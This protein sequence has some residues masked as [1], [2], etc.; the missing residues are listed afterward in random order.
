M[1]AAE[2]KKVNLLELSYILSIINNREKKSYYISIYW[3]NELEDAIRSRS[4]LAVWRT[5]NKISYDKLNFGR[6][7]KRVIRS[8]INSFETREGDAV[9]FELSDNVDFKI[10]NFSLQD[11]INVEDD[12]LNKQFINALVK[13]ANIKR[14]DKQLVLNFFRII[15]KGF[16]KTVQDIK[17]NIRRRIRTETDNVIMNFTDREN[18]L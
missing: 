7:E 16:P 13:M 8:I 3:L 11:I 12:L 1:C 2:L 4:K 6:F 14:E 9:L 5:F 10:V 18:E 17:D 15:C